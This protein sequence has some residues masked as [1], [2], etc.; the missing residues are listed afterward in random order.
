M[1]HLGSGRRLVWRRVIVD[2]GFLSMEPLFIG[3]AVI[4]P[5]TQRTVVVLVRMPVRAVFPLWALVRMMMRHMIVIVRMQAHRMIMSRNG[6]LT[7]NVLNS[8]YALRPCEAGLM[9]RRRRS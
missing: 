9:V 8:H 6:A 7:V 3:R 4:V 5:M 2:V 1:L